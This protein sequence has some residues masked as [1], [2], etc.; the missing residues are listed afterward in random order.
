MLKHSITSFLAALCI[1]T[2]DLRRSTGIR[3]QLAEHRAR[4]CL[5]GLTEIQ[6]YWKINDTVLDLFFQYLD[7]ATAKRPQTNEPDLATGD[8]FDTTRPFNN[9]DNLGRT[10]VSVVV[11]Q[12][13]TS[14]LTS[15]SHIMDNWVCDYNMFTDT[16]MYTNVG[17]DMQGFEMLQRYL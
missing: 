12:H 7:K 9:T 10:P 11:P 15:L 3:R 13:D 16:D 8:G 17:D 1:H 6:K 2:I 5:M 14:E 4:I